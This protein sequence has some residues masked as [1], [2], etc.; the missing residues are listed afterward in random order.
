[1]RRAPDVPSP[2]LD[3]RSGRPAFQAG[4]TNGGLVMM[5]KTV[6]A[7]LATD[8]PETKGFALLDATF[9]TH[10]PALRGRLI[11]LTRDPAVAED[12]VSECFLRLAT[13]ID[14]GRTPT[15]PAAWLYRVGRNVAI[16]RARRN[17]VATRAMPGLF[18]RGV[19]AS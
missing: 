12:I 16:S 3:R 19:A 6:P 7:L 1:M 10:A 4:R 11:A 14:A 15:E 2:A 5:A 17:A 8:V 18:D 13:E 9:R